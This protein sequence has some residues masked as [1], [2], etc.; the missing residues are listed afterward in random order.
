MSVLSCIQPSYI[1]WKGYFH[2]IQKSDIFVFL[3]DV[4][5]DKHS[6]RNRNKIKTSNGL[7]WLTVPILTK[8][9]FGQ[10]I[11]EVQINNRNNWRKKHL[12]AIHMNYIKAPFFNKHKEFLA[13][14]YEREWKLLVD[15]DIY[16]TVEISKLLGIKTNFIRASEIQLKQDK[17]HRLID[18]CKILNIDTYLTGPLARN[19]LTAEM[20]EKEGLKLE[21]QE[22]YYNEYP[23]LYGDFV[24]NVSI[25]DTLFNCGEE[26]GEY[27][28]GKYAKKYAV[29]D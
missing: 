3:D 16:L 11:M 29:S 26:A 25:I 7:I 1:P 14:V 20:F 4:Q 6:W 19:Y 8:K 17:I 13:S 21:F 24:H 18:L 2:Q 27:I 23:Q 5:Y 15:L 28:W 10:S 22:Y 9:R 12:K